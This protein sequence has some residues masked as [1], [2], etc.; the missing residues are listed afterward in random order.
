MSGDVSAVA[1][2]NAL[3]KARK[4]KPLVAQATKSFRSVG[5]RQRYKTPTQARTSESCLVGSL[6]PAAGNCT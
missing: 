6:D 2:R 1:T 5:S 3:D 4:N